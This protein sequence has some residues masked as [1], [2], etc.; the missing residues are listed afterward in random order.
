M[1]HPYK[2]LFISFE[3]L[4]FCGKS[5]QFSLFE[6]YIKEKNIPYTNI[7]EPGGTIIGEQIRGI[8]LDEHNTEMSFETELLLFSASR[9]QLVKQ[10]VIPQLEAGHLVISDRFHDTGTAYQAY[11]RQLGSDFVMGAHRLALHDLNS[12]DNM[13]LPDLTFFFDVSVETSFKRKAAAKRI[14][15]DRIEE[16]EKDLFERAREGYLIITKSEPQRF[17]CID[18]ERDIE[19]IY[20][21]VIKLADPLLKEKYKI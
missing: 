6:K 21:D 8:L 4:D 10:V 19:E 11:G 5:K 18:A 12:L 16:S 2:G 15:I 7:R 9:A 1:S 20:Q 17:K 13:L 3:G 14:K